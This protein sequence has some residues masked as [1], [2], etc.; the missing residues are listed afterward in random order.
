[1]K[2]Y[3]QITLY[4]WN[5]G[6]EKAKKERD[7]KK[8]ALCASGFRQPTNIRN[9]SNTKCFKIIFSTWHYPEISCKNKIALSISRNI[10]QNC[11]LY[12]SHEENGRCSTVVLFVGLNNLFCHLKYLSVM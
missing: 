8:M 4:E 1:M 11:S 2:R 5:G 7:I 12:G 9:I 10:R 6:I 3:W